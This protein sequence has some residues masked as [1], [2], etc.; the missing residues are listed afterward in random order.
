MGRINSQSDTRTT[1]RVFINK[2][3][4][5][6]FRVPFVR[7]GLVNTSQ[8]DLYP[9]KDKKILDVGCGG[10]ILSEVT[11]FIWMLSHLVSVIKL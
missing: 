5:Y 2:T 6:I 7:D 8:R 9:L 1:K 10:G 4:V 3:I 11:Y